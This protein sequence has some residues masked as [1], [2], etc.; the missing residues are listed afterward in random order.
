MNRNLP[1]GVFDSG[2][3]GL[4]VAREIVNLLP[5]EDIIYLGDTARV[6]YGN[7]GKEV[8]TAFAKDL[9][10]FLLDKKVKALVVACNTISAT[11]LPDLQAM[12]FI[13]LIGVIQPSAEMIVKAT[14]NK[15]VGIIGTK[16]TINS[17]IYTSEIKKIDS[18]I[19]VVSKACP[20]FVPLAEEGLAES[21]VAELVAKKYLSDLESIDTLHLGCTHYP[22][23]RNTIQKVLPAVKIIDSANPTAY[24][25]QKLL[26]IKNLLNKKN[27]KG[28]KTFYVTDLSSTVQEVAASFFGDNITQN[29]IKVSL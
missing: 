23:L 28:E 11:C 17:G 12:A 2:I 24:E 9:V 3:G 20:L 10:S 22:L 4:T 16:A 13:P 7:R 21:E 18:S 1:I 15:R 8:I 26:T 19:A 27:I 6:P 5:H 14:S 25:L 29:I